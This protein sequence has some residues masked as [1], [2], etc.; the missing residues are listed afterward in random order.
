MLHS[1]QDLT[2]ARYVVSDEYTPEVHTKLGLESRQRCQGR[3]RHHD[4][5]R[6]AEDFPEYLGYMKW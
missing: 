5:V 3:A 1:N 6:L 4:R 2:V